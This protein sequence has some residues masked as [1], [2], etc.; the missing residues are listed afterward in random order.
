MKSFFC[1]L[2]SVFALRQ[3]GCEERSLGGAARHAQVLIWQ[4]PQPVKGLKV[5]EPREIQ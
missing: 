3:S 2:Y 4:T 5:V 1:A